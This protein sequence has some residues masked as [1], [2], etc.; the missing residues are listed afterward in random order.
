MSIVQE[1]EK[2]F[3]EAY[4][5]KGA[6]VVSSFTEFAQRHGPVG[7]QQAALGLLGC[8]AIQAL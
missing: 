4:L 6:K 8:H 7:S 5:E 1:E 2:V 3:N